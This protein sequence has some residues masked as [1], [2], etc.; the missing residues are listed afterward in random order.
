MKTAVSCLGA[1]AAALLSS[2]LASAQELAPGEAPPEAVVDPSLAAPV[3]PPVTV[4]PTGQWVEQGD[5]GPVW[6]PVGA[7]AYAY[8]A[9]PYVY[10]YTPAYGWGWYNS[11]WGWGAYTGR[12]WLTTHWGVGP[13][14]GFGA[15]AGRWFAPH[16]AFG[17]YP[18]ASH[19]GVWGHNYG[20]GY[21]AGAGHVATFHAGGFHGG[22]VHFGG[23]GGGFHGRR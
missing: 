8:G 10:L 14:V 2:T 17:R 13:R 16:A 4:A 22:A 21:R 15:G 11:P 1:L 5:Y 7:S 23:H 20:Y 18:Y 19:A 3:P 9:S 6:V 12:P